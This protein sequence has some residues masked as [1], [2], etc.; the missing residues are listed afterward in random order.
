MC[1]TPWTTYK[2]SSY[3]GDVL[4]IL[5][6]EIALSVDI[7]ISAKSLSGRFG[8]A[9]SKAITSV[10]LFLP[11]YFKLSS[12]IL[13]SFTKERVISP[14]FL[15]PSD[16]RTFWTAFTAFLELT[17]TL[18]CRFFMIILKLLCLLGFPDRLYA[19]GICR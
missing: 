11:R 2:Y 5:A 17:G 3:K 16:H 12:L 7:T 4:K 10:G 6:L 19:H 8:S 1:N 14:D 18:F 15:M 9:R 13:R